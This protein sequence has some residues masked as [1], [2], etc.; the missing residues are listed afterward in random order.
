MLCRQLYLLSRSGGRRRSVLRSFATFCCVLYG[1]LVSFSRVA[2]HRH[3][4]TDVL[5][6]A[7]LGTAAG[8]ILVRDGYRACLGGRGTLLVP[9]IR[10]HGH[11]T[12]LF[13]IYTI[14]VVY[15]PQCFNATNPNKD[16]FIYRLSLGSEKTVIRMQG[17]CSWLAHS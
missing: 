4:L 5:A 14:Y 10:G 13:I 12:C 1:C 6:G 16:F 3:H 11:S 2:D 9:E 7:A 15:K 17:R 8:A